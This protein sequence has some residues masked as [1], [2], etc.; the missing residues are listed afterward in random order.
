MTAW[1]VAR[2]RTFSLLLHCSLGGSV[3]CLPSQA[4]AGCL[5]QQDADEQPGGQEPGAGGCS[6]ALPQDPIPPKLLFP[7]AI[8]RGHKPTFV[9][10][11]GGQK[12][13]NIITASASCDVTGFLPSVSPV[14]H[15][16]WVARA[17]AGPG[18][19]SGSP[20]SATPT[21]SSAVIILP[22]DP[23][24][25]SRAAAQCHPYMLL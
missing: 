10:A 8:S 12:Y 19:V 20:V 2:K 3:F 5:C 14:L 9:P 17:G 22:L 15:P 16:V 1:T 18:K 11:P 21:P 23:I 7:C 25:C 4:A 6:G 13:K 24:S